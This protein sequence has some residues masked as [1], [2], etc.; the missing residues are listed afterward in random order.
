VKGAVSAVKKAARRAVKQVS[1]PPPEGKRTIR[2]SAKEIARKPLAKLAAK[3]ATRK[4]GRKA[5][6]KKT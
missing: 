6:V 1:S 2:K 3:K 5:A 4:T